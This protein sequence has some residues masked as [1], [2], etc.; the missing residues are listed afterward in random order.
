MLVLVPGAAAAGVSYEVSVRPV[1]PADQ[2]L[3]LP[4]PQP[5]VTQYFVDDG[6]VRVGGDA[7]KTAYLFKDRTMYVIDGTGRV[8]HELTHATLR[9]VG[10]HYAEAVKQLED[11]AAAAPPDQREAA[12]KK[13]ADL[14]L[15][16]DRLI[17]PVP[18]TY[19]VTVRF[20]SVDGRAC[21]IWEERENDAKR[22]ELCVAPTVSVPGGA[23]ILRGMKTLSEFRQGSSF[24]FGVDLGLSDWWS[25]FAG[26]GGV[27]L[28][29]REYK[30][31]S[32][33]AEV[34]LSAMRPGPVSPALFDPPADFRVQQGPEYAQ[35]YVR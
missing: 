10:A 22:M 16:S 3:S 9:A 1:D 15:A 24:A 2:A 25:D 14:R 13:A 11:A 4:A 6:K 28:L 30:Y 21:R 12:E 17:Q 20:E 34:M 32:V 31:D 29:I 19:R 18:R 8:V 26:F 23:D 7:A 27:P 33:V 5:V 35:W